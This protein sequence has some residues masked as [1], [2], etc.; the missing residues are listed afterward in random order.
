MKYI[1]AIATIVIFAVIILI[2]DSLDSM[3]LVWAAL[4][5]ILLGGFGFLT[6]MTVL[7]VL[8]ATAPEQQLRQRSPAP[9]RIQ[10]QPDSKKQPGWL[11]LL[12]LLDHLRK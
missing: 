3:P 9:R 4:G 6:I 12:H 10:L 8:K 5:G 1:A 7:K 2:A 11:Q